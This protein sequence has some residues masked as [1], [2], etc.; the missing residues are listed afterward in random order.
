MIKCV[1]IDDE[2]PAIN[3][4]QNYIRRMENLELVGTAT[5]PFAGVDLIRRSKAD[6][7]FLDIQMD[8]MTGIE[9]MNLLDPSV[10]VIFCTA[11]S[12]FAVESYELN[13]VDYLVKPIAFSRFV[14]AVKR[15]KS[16]DKQEQPANDSIADDYIFVK[17]EQKGKMV[18]INFDEIDFIEGQNN[19]IAIHSGNKKTLIYATM[20]ELEGYLAPSRFIR[21]HKSFIVA[22]SKIVQVENNT[23]FLKNQTVKIPLSK[24]YKDF[25]LEKVKDKILSR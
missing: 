6:V 5:D 20:K 14:K 22:S 10:Q 23:I 17:A 19:Y 2:Q 11:F 3:V 13:A 9:V 16:N 4:I 7:V 1:I 8:E 12:E 15:I 18:R 21:V 24:T 25:F